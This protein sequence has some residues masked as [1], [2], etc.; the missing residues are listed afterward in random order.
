MSV[1]LREP[2]TLRQLQL[3]VHVAN[4]L[5]FDEISDEEGIS[6]KTVK[7][8]LDDARSRMGARNLP[9]LVAL[10]VSAGMLVYLDDTTD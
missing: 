8:H 10:A 9:N 3:L 4:G 2:M 5:T 7:R 1:T 6:P